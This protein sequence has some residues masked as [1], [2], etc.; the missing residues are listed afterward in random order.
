MVKRTVDAKSTV[1]QKDVKLDVL[2][3]QKESIAH[4]PMKEMKDEV[5]ARGLVKDAK[6]HGA[7]LKKTALSQGPVMAGRQHARD[8]EM[9]KQVHGGSIVASKVVKEFLVTLGRLDEELNSG[10][11]TKDNELT[12]GVRELT[13]LCNS[14]MKG[15]ME[16]DEFKKESKEIVRGIKLPMTET[17]KAQ[18]FCEHLREAVRSMLKVMD[19][20]V[21]S[22]ATLGKKH[23]MDHTPGA[24]TMVGRSH[25]FNP[26]TKDSKFGAV[27]KDFEHSLDNLDSKHTHQVKL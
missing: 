17:R 3:E 14:Y 24:R 13:K 19:W 11:K 12:I 25:F 2:R 4:R 6:T 9:K 7:S 26:L 21:T 1:K 22:V 10:K 5:K 15:R 18:T 27:V 16:Y 23:E 8:S 20:V